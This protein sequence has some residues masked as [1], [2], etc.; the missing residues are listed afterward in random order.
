[1]MVVV[2]ETHGRA[3]LR[4]KQYCENNIAKQYCENNIAKQ[5]CK[6]ILRKQYYKTILQCDIMIP[7]NN[8]FLP[9]I[10]C[11]EGNPVFRHGHPFVLYK[12][13]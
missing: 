11:Y 1:M 4:A 10:L 7:A 13:E 2:V 8:F 5:Y 3:S 9:Q 12:Q 6:T